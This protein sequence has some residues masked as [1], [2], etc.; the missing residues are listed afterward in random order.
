[1]NALERQGNKLAMTCDPVSAEFAQLRGKKI[2][3]ISRC[4]WSLFN[5]RR[6]LALFLQSC[7]ANVVTAGGGGDGYEARMGEH[8]IE[9]RTVPISQTGMTPL[10]DLRFFLYMVY[11]FLRER[12][13]IVHFFTIKPA[14]Y[15]NLAARV[16]GV[17]IRITTVTGLGYAFRKESRLLQ[18]VAEF[19]YRHALA[20]GQRVF[21]QNADDMDLFV[22]KGI[23]KR[24]AATLAQGSGVDLSWFAPGAGEGIIQKAED[25]VTFAMI[26]RLLREKGVLLYLEAAERIRAQGLNARF[27]LVGDVDPGNPHSLT[28]AEL[29]LIRGSRALHWFGR[30][31]DVRPYLAATDVVVLPSYYREG[32]PKT[33]LE[34]AAMEKAIITTDAVGCREAVL[35]GKTGVLV[36]PRDIEA[37]TAAAGRLAQDPALVRAM[38]H[39]G[40]RYIQERFDENQ[41]LRDTAT[42]YL[43]GLAARPH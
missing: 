1:M 26:S 43:A 36:P 16:A 15:G 28:D 2:V 13:D 41:I 25:K 22:N 18:A 37:L 39:A 7:G 32:V 10:A 3:L 27:I 31:D 21:F 14:V 38:G 20:R 5:F 11:W 8:G 34:G 24:A 4:S 6:G 9:F 17:P 19:L 29:A 42:S 35:D 12:P 33:L 23:V 30:V 40:R